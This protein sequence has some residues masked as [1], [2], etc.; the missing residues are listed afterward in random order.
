M[1]HTSTQNM[2]LL[3]VLLVLGFLGFMFLC[4]GLSLA[5]ITALSGTPQ[6]APAPILTV[7]IPQRTLPFATPTPTRSS[8]A[9]PPARE[10]APYTPEADME[11]RLLTWIYE[12]V[13]PSVVNIQTDESE[14]SGFV[15]DRRGHIVTNFHVVHGAEHIL[16]TFFDNTQVQAQLIGEDADSDLAVIRVDPKEVELRPVVLG[17][18]L[19][20]KVGERAIAIGNPFGL[21]GS[22]TAG[23]ISALGRDIEAPSTYLIPEAIQTD[24]PVNPG[25]SGG[26]LL[27]ARGEVIGI[28]SQIRSP[29]RANTGVGFAIPI[30]IAKRIVPVLIEKGAYEHPFIGVSGIT[31]SAEINEH[32]GF[33][34]DLR[35]A[36]V[37]QALA[38]FPAAKAG[39]RGGK[40]KT[41]YVIGFDESG[42][43]LYLKRG[44]DVIIAIND[45]PVR[46]F[47]DLLV[48]LIR[49]AS[50]GDTVTLTVWRNGK[51][52]KIPVTLGVRPR[53]P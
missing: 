7:V 37:N 43:P 49:Y 6:G 33:P 51:I 2:P 44:G 53:R 50:P 8:V 20:L 48:Y 14:G 36:Y 32:L 19:S 4:V 28:V 46:R 5:L 12:H 42:R 9:P 1:D 17:D 24:A 40:E 3:I 13:N 21:A 39:I 23:I 10:V 29:V 31:L 47:D 30:H 34:R 27:N 22:M 18:S 52:L 15:W 38:G 11:T 25:N 16:V 45:Q 35:G 26:P 41:D